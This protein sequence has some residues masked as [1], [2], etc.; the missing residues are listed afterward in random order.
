MKLELTLRF[1]RVHHFFTSVE[2]A[3]YFR[4]ELVLFRNA[5]PGTFSS[6]WSY[7]LSPAAAHF[8]ISA[9]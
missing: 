5:V 1:A 3:G 9:H 8:P 4:I 2:G 7:Y 6:S